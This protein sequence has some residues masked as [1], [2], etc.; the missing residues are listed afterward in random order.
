MNY[1]I[2]FHSGPYAGQSY[3]LAKDVI[4]LG[5]LDEMDL[6]IQDASVSSRHAEL[7]LENGQWI[8]T[9]LNSTNGSTVNKTQATTVAL[10]DGDV[11]GVGEVL[12][13]FH[14]S[15]QRLP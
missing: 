3:E 6:P 15:A 14:A 9:D 12:F 4:M 8:F 13:E 10:A 1:S 5:R 11:I 2:T 7:R